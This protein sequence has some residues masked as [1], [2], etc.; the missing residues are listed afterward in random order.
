[1]GGVTVVHLVQHGE[2][3]RLPGDPGL[4]ETGRQQATATARWLRSIQLQALYSSPLRRA[5][6]TAD[7]IAAVTGLP[8][9]RDARLRERMNWDGS[10]SLEDFLAEWAHATLDRDFVPS[11][12]ES[13]RRAGDR[14]RA[15]L[16][17]L[18]ARPAPVAAVTH[19]GVTIDL[20]RNLLPDRALPPSLLGAGIPP[21]AITTLD[22]LDV[23][24]I[25]ATEHLAS[26]G[27]DG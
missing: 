19:G 6:A 27:Y 9:Q 13:S 12:G 8:V 17:A 10:C 20:L 3:Q 26:P 21:C 2:K 5:E 16:L 23:V 1:L 24:T 11:G 7:L 15:F 25:A 4:T 22:G 14:L 18:P